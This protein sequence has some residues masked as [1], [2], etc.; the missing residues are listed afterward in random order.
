MMYDVTRPS[1]LDRLKVWMEEAQANCKANTYGRSVKYFIIGNKID[2]CS[3]DIEI[4]EQSAFNFAQMLTIP[5][6]HVFRISVKTAEGLDKLQNEL[7]RILSDN[8]LPAKPHNTSNP[9]IDLHEN[10]KEKPPCPCM[11]L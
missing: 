5:K 3:T 7:G 4:D 9:F 1:T 6:E 2:S 11:L 10:P 8:M